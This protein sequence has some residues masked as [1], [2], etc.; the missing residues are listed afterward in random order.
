MKSVFKIFLNKLRSTFRSTDQQ[1]QQHPHQHQQKREESIK[2]DSEQSN[3]IKNSR[4]DSSLGSGSI[5]LGNHSKLGNLIENELKK[6]GCLPS[7]KHQIVIR[8]SSATCSPRRP[9]A[10][11]P[12][13]Q[14]GS[15]KSTKSS[16]SFISTLSGKSVRSVGQLNEEPSTTTSSFTGSTTNL[17]QQRKNVS[18]Q[19]SNDTIS[20]TSSIALLFNP[21]QSNKPQFE[22]INT[23]LSKHKRIGS[24]QSLLKN[25][26]P[27]DSSSHLSSLADIVPEL[28]N[29]NEDT[30]Q[31]QLQQQHRTREL[32]R[33][34]SSYSI[35]DLD[36]D[37]SDGSTIFASSPNIFIQSTTNQQQFSNQPLLISQ[38]MSMEEPELS[39]T[40]SL[41]AVEIDYS[42]GHRSKSVDASV[43]MA[44]K[45]QNLTAS[46]TQKGK[47]S[48][49]SATL[50]IPKWRLFIRKPSNAS[51]TTLNTNLSNLGAN[52][53]ISSNSN[54]IS[55]GGVSS[56]NLD[57]NATQQQQQQ[58]Q[59]QQA[60]QIATTTTLTIIKLADIFK[61]CIH[62]RWIDLIEP[63]KI[64]PSD[65][66]LLNDLFSDSNNNML[67]ENQSLEEED[68]EEFSDD[69]DSE[70][71]D[72]CHQHT[73]FCQS[74]FQGNDFSS[75]AVYH[76]QQSQQTSSAATSS[77]A[78]RY[79]KNRQRR[80]SYNVTYFSKPLANSQQH[81]QQTAAS[82]NQRP[83]S[84]T[85]FIKKSIVDDKKS[86]EQSDKT[87]SSDKQPM[88][89]V[90]SVTLS[91]ASDD[92]L[93]QQQ[94]QQEKD[95]MNNLMNAS[96][97]FNS[98]NN[99]ETQFISIQITEPTS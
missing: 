11:P 88:F 94:E 61:D 51:T 41:I 47:P 89:R 43:V 74:S 4:S 29:L 6:K 25:D 17:N 23:K 91:E 10:H 54:I 92:E 16:R 8:C 71:Q 60:N 69:L 7:R 98:D 68:E 35:K 85:G 12:V 15:N 32:N 49:S 93:Q 40:D 46:S 9:L 57:T 27:N 53:A 90:P 56:S 86:D 36:D 55:S 30:Q 82:T 62:C 34:G 45:N 38:S 64:Y 39:D 13:K 66:Q 33:D 28:P 65:S 76:Q 44:M 79:V 77:G 21:P 2:D 42:K 73:H 97:V 37:E 5:L 58:Q 87:N 63:K 80:S 83:L 70:E 19:N 20:T 96:N 52:I 24:N 1:Q 75:T 31:Q 78:R 48:R 50:Q 84:A 18:Y 14:Y 3:K 22:Q 59:Q 72:E 99:A 26:S 67:T 95:A 81:P